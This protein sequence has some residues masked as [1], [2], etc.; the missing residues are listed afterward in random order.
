MQGRQKVLNIFGILL[1]FSTL[2]TIGCRAGK[3]ELLNKGKGQASSAPQGSH[4]RAT[5]L[6]VKNADLTCIGTSCA[7][8]YKM[9]LNVRQGLAS[10]GPDTYNTGVPAVIVRG[11]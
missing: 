7:T 8:N 1:I 11:K 5:Q 10:S 2:N 3:L 6:S 9:T 4:F